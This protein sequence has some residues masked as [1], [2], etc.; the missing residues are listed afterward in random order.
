MLVRAELH[1]VD[2]AVCN[3]NVSEPSD[4]V[5]D[6]VGAAEGA[7]IRLEYA[8]SSPWHPAGMIPLAATPE[9]PYWT[10]IFTSLRTA[11]DDTGYAETAAQMAALAA[12]QPGFLGIEH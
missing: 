11:D 5:G 12:T 7:R 8:R 3:R 2:R 10:V 9:P 1:V 6:V 4:F